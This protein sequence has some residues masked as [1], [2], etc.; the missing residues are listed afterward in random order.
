MDLI[1]KVKNDK[2]ELDSVFYGP[3]NI[4]SSYPTFNKKLNEDEDLK[5]IV[6]KIPNEES[7]FYYNNQAVKQIFKP[8]E[9]EDHHIH[10]L[11]Y[12][13]LEKIYMDSMYLK[14]NNSTLAFINGIDLFTKFAF[15]KLF[16]IDKKS[17]AVS[18][19]QST[20]VFNS[21]LNDMNSK[22]PK[23]KIG[24]VITD[25]GSEFLG[26][27]M[28]NLN[29]KDIPHI[30]A[31]AGDKRKTSPIERFNRTIRLYL[32][33][34]K[35]IYG[36]IDN[37][38]LIKI[39]DAYNNIEHAELHATPNEILKD[40]NLQ[41]QN[42]LHFMELSKENLQDILPDGSKVRKLLDISQFQKI[43]PVWSKEIYSIKKYSKNT[44]ELVGD[45]GFYKRDQLQPINEPTLLN[46]KKVNIIK[47]EDDSDNG[48][49]TIYESPTEKVSSIPTELLGLRPSSIVKPIIHIMKPNKE[50]PT[51]LIRTSGREIKK[52]DILDL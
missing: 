10:I 12:Y 50:E 6:N 2:P 17:Q 45:S 32:Q 14:L 19:A 41:K 36:K 23:L 25:L 15:S 35:S 16:I 34:Y 28:K 43:R 1:Q 37:N 9:A 20:A 3:T 4:M 24:Y 8:F 40:S 22:Y 46:D 39:I 51:N 31:N 44:Y 21:F 33:K 47:D 30:Y 48:N 18:S 52:R 38:V 7:H 26:D 49:S 5:H 11:A 13:P 29:N 27:F 42:E